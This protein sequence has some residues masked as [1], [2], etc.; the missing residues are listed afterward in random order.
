MSIGVVVVESLD[1]WATRTANGVEN[2]FTCFMYILKLRKGS[3][4]CKARINND[5]SGSFQLYIF[6]VP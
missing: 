3:I 4:T 1:K 5:V 6:L 2:L